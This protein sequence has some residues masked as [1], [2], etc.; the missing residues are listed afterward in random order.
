MSTGSIPVSRF[1]NK[2]TIPF[3]IVLLFS[4]PD[5][6]RRF[7]VYAP[8]RSAQAEVHRTSCAVSRFL[9]EQQGW[10]FDFSFRNR[11][12]L[13]GVKATVFNSSTN[14]LLFSTDWHSCKNL[15][16]QFIFNAFIYIKRYRINQIILP[17]SK[18][19]LTPVFHKR[20]LFQII[21]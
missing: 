6:A 19:I 8:L 1:H 5:R 10:Y 2:R 13:K 16:Q 21:S 17:Q 18:F 9:I 7:D 15:F 3:G 4:S 11:F 12:R 14:I 20:I